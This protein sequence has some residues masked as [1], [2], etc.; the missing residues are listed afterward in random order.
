MC[1]LVEVGMQGKLWRVRAVDYR[2]ASGR[3]VYFRAR[4]AEVSG[5]AEFFSFSL[6]SVRALCGCKVQG[7]GLR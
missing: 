2:W 5:R 3:A 6:L 1:S 4:V 7:C